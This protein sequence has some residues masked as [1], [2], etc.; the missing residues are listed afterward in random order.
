[1][2]EVYTIALTH[3]TATVED[4]FL[5]SCGFWDLNSG[6]QACQQAPLPP[7]AVLPSLPSL[8]TDFVVAAINVDVVV[9]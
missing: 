2:C 8:K 7:E 4:D 6:Y 5:P 3:V 9:V 1:M